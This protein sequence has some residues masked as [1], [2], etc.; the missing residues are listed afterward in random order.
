[1]E[2]PVARGNAEEV[3]DFRALPLIYSQPEMLAVTRLPDIP[4]KTLADGSEL[5]MD[6]Y[7]PD[8]YDGQT[9]LP[10]LLFVHGDASPE[11]IGNAKDWACFIGWGELVASAG[12]A[13]V[14]FNH[15]STQRLHNVHEA[16][17]DVDDLLRYVRAHSHELGIDSE[18]LGIWTCSAGSYL[19]LRTA[20]RGSPTW[21]RCAISYYG[22]ADLHVFFPG[23]TGPTAAPGGE[24]A[25]P[26]AQP[27]AATFQ[28]F[29]TTAALRQERSIPPLLIVRAGLDNA[30]LNAGIDE[31]V[32]AALLRNLDL[33]FLN[34]ATGHHAF[35][36]LDDNGR[37]HEI[38]SATLAFIKMHLA[39]G[40]RE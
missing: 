38:I 16:A 17:A 10:A 2:E 34:H 20:L 24:S 5:Q 14:T 29:S 15:R 12:L 39:P 25:Q 18:R 40:A 8:T 26:I 1:M 7:Y 30:A 36:I 22:V 33:T 27:D 23:S 4:Y 6:V 35:D 28:E 32:H 19:G 31:L 3:P 13:A 11:F 9:L 37:S 21:V